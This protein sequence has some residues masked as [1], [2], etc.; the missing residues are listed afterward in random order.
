ME[1][2]TWGAEPTQ[3]VPPFW[4]L[5][6][7][8]RH[9]MAKRR[10]R[11]GEQP[12]YAPGSPQDPTE[13]RPGEQSSLQCL[14]SRLLPCRLAAAQEDRGDIH[15]LALPGATFVL[16]YPPA[17]FHLC[18]LC[19]YFYC[20]FWFVFPPPSLSLFLLVWSLGVQVIL[21]P[22]GWKIKSNLSL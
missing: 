16:F 6:S 18:S 15:L 12:F 8:V 4:G 22:K 7:W 17:F 3:Y 10:S 9:D 11:E 2:G 13:I 21:K 20:V 1:G 19:I 5:Q 14:L